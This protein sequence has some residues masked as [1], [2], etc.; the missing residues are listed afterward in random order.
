MFSKNLHLLLAYLCCEFAF[1]A[2][3]QC[4]VRTCDLN[5]VEIANQHGVSMQGKIHEYHMRYKLSS[6]AFQ[7]GTALI[8]DNIR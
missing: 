5:C 2:H 3:F 1:R 4:V 6:N 7:R 8:R